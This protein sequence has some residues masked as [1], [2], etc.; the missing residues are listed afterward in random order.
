MAGTPP[1]TRPRRTAPAARRASTTTTKGRTRPQGRHRARRAAR[2]RMRAP[3]GDE[4][5][6]LRTGA[7]SRP[8][9]R[10]VPPVRRGTT[11]KGRRGSVRQR[12]ILRAGATNC[13]SAPRH[14]L[15]PA[16][17]LH[18]LQQ[19]HVLGDDRRHRLLR[20]RRGQVPEPP[21]DAVLRAVR[22][23]KVLRQVRD[24]GVHALHRRQDEQ[25]GRDVMP[26][27]RHGALVVR[28]GVQLHDLRRGLL[29]RGR[30]KEAANRFFGYRTPGPKQ[31]LPCIACE[32]EGV[33]CIAVGAQLSTLKLRDGYFRIAAHSHRG[34]RGVRE[35]PM[36]K[37]CKGGGNFSRSGNS[38]C[39]RGYRGPLCAVCERKYYRDTTNDLCVECAETSTSVELKRRAPIVMV[40]ATTLAIR[41][42][43]SLGKEQRSTAESAAKSTA[44]SAA[45]DRRK[46]SCQKR[47]RRR[48]TG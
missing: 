34:V 32:A 8:R 9:A 24:S 41:K 31:L 16:P 47:W 13:T 27:L 29:P 23:G 4:L 25:R 7:T 43:A 48:S 30:G 2:G 3:Q 37:A 5:R 1:F 36:K 39:R 10:K 35:C 14:L 22:R 38:Y 44:E 18:G 28:R 17:R 42:M 46:S 33:Q 19:R 45:A 6:S 21:R 15:G 20:V 12:E 26:G 11:P 40:A